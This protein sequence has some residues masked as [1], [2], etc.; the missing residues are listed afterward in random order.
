[1]DPKGWEQSALTH[2]SGKPVRPLFL[3]TWMSLEL[4]C[5]ERRPH[6]LTGGPWGSW[7]ITLHFA[8]WN[9]PGA[10]A[11]LAPHRACCDLAVLFSDGESSGYIRS[12]AASEG[13]K[14]VCNLLRPLPLLLYLHCDND[15][16]H[17]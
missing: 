13:L 1:M 14:R 5:L 3:K 10:K 12:G 8:A 2:C 11:R 6:L 15:I 4:G 16:P 9:E 17:K 7:S